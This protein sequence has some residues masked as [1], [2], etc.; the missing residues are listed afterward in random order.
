M[1]ALE[2][3]ILDKIRLLDRPAKQRVLEVLNRELKQQSELRPDQEE[4]PFDMKAWL[5]RVDAMRAEIDADPNNNHSISALDLLD[6]LRDE[7][8]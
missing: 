7:E 4:T 8:S 1:S 2:Q 5:A 6:E 3:E